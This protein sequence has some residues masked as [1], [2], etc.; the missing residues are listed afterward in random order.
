MSC[1]DRNLK[2]CLKRGNRAHRAHWLNNVVDA[3]KV[4]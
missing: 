2:S 4:L 1:I 3:I